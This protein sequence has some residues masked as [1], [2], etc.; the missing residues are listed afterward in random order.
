MSFDDDL[1]TEEYYREEDSSFFQLTAPIGGIKFLINQVLIFLMTLGIAFIFAILGAIIPVLVFIAIPVIM[2]LYWVTYA[3]RMWDILGDRKQAS[4]AA[5]VMV[6][7]GFTGI[8]YI[9]MVVALTVIKG[10]LIR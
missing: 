2:Y 4:I 6:L 7:F 5:I 9:V 10:K 1:L 3:S 8:F